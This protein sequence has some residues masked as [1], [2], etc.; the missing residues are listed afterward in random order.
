[1]GKDGPV[2]AGKEKCRHVAGAAEPGAGA[3]GSQWGAQE[4][5]GALTAKETPVPGLYQQDPSPAA[6]WFLTQSGALGSNRQG[7]QQGQEPG[8]C[9][10]GRGDPLSCL[11]GCGEL[12]PDTLGVQGQRRSW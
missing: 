10:L 5:G 7:T 3:S 11:L 8:L 2:G 9:V 4:A 6:G 12:E 1:M